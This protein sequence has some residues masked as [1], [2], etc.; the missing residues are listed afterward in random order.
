MCYPPLK[1]V[2]LLRK[3]EVSIAPSL[4]IGTL[5]S[6]LKN[7]S[8]VVQI[9]MLLRTAWGFCPGVH[10]PN[11]VGFYI[12]ELSILF[13]HLRHE[14]ESVLICGTDVMDNLYFLMSS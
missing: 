7:Y 8:V 1:I 14:A 11:K 10:V 9:S 2:N 5:L 3:L 4:K 6:A 12:V 13:F